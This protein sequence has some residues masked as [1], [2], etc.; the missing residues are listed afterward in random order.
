MSF[1]DVFAALYDFHPN[2]SHTLSTLI[3][4]HDY[5]YSSSIIFD[6][7]V[8]IIIITVMAIVTLH[9]K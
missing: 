3:L 4:P 1:T 6:I 9:V 8:I 7:I 2:S 5:H